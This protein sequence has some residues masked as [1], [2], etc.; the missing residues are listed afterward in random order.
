M[1]YARSVRLPKLPFVGSATLNDKPA[2]VANAMAEALGFD[3][4]ARAACRTWEEALRHF[5]AQADS[6]G[7]LVMV[8]G[9]VLSNKET[10]LPMSLWTKP[11]PG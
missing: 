6:I 9:V 11:S 7:V 4:A 8:S 3:I 1:D 2:A 10:S 5:I